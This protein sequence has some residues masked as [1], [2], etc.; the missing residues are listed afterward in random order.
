M[1]RAFS[2]PNRGMDEIVIGAPIH[3]S[4]IIY[5]V[6]RCKNYME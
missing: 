4:E 5:F 1:P 3:P 2:V 6:G